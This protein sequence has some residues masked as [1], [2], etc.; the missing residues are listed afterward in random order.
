M[1]HKQQRR[2][3]EIKAGM[4]QQPQQSG[5]SD[6]DL[7]EEMEK[8]HAMQ[9]SQAVPATHTD[10]TTNE[11][12]PAGNNTENETEPLSSEAGAQQPTSTAKTESYYTREYR[13]WPQEREDRSAA[14]RERLE[15]EER[16][17]QEQ[18]KQEEKEREKERAEHEEERRVVEKALLEE[19]ERQAQAT[20]PKERKEEK[21]G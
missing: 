5:M 12:D 1:L 15:A 13:T 19:E 11:W 16:R 2:W 7:E 21:G 9:S 6:V 20:K 3:D 10:T 18:K 17:K 8:D 14:G 4:Q